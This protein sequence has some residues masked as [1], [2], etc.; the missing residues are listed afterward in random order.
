MLILSQVVLDYGVL[1]K[2]WAALVIIPSILSQ[3]LGRTTHSTWLQVYRH[4]VTQNTTS[5]HACLIKTR[6]WYKLCS[7][8]SGIAGPKNSEQQSTWPEYSN[9]PASIWDNERSNPWP[10]SS[11]SPTTPTA[12][13]SS[14]TALPCCYFTVKVNESSWLKWKWLILI[15]K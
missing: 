4:S 1:L 7:V 15:R 13:R 10:S 3:H 8:F 14:E 6:C 9:V 2:T 5:Q 12:V 11:G